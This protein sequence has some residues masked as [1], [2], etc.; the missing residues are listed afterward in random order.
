MTPE[1]IEAIGIYIIMP[2]C[3]AMV[4]LRLLGLASRAR[5]EIERVYEISGKKEKQE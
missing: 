1:I 3:G 2:I 4:F 5:L